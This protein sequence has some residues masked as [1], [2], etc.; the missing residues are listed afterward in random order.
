M[1]HTNLTREE[2][3]TLFTHKDGIFYNKIHRN[4]R[5]PIG[6]VSGT[7]GGQG[8]VYIRIQGKDY[9]RGRLVWMWYGKELPEGKYID[10]IN[11]DRADDRIENLRMVTHQEN[12]QNRN[13]KGYTY[14][15][16]KG[17]YKARI[18]VGLKEIYLGYFDTSE[19]AREAYLKAKKE[20]HIQT[21]D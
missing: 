10:H 18:G 2:L 21:G 3:E 19:E 1:T 14:Y 6:A 12:Q 13:A 7:V 4:G 20:L 9:R 8:Y 11:R 15:K 16:K 5:A 17:K